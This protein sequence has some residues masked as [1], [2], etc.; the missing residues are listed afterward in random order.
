MP[1]SYPTRRDEVFGRDKR[2]S[3][4]EGEFFK[5]DKVEIVDAAPA[6]LRRCRAWDLA[7]TKGRKTR[8]IEPPRNSAVIAYQFTI[9]T[10]LKQ[11]TPTPK[12]IDRKKR[13]AG[14]SVQT[15]DTQPSDLL[16]PIAN[17][18]RKGVMDRTGSVIG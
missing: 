16:Y 18:H 15:S 17:E 1:S 2:P 4:K 3:A 13:A 9:R 14:K 6:N 10:P 11:I 5:M 7:A 12:A 8:A